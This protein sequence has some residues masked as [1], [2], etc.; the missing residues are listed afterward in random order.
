MRRLGYGLLAAAATVSAITLSTATANAGIPAGVYCAG[1]FCYNTT[2]QPQTV[3][4]TEVCPNGPQY[5]VSGLIP[6]HGAGAVGAFACPNGVQP[7][8]ILY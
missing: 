7:Q 1:T 6:P 3:T 2:D 4:G 5:A 8:G